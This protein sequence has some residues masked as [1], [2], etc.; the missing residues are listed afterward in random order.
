MGPSQVPQTDD[1]REFDLE[2]AEPERQNRRQEATLRREYDREA[3]RRRA[4]HEAQAREWRELAQRLASERRR[5]TIQRVK[6]RVI[7]NWSALGYLIPAEAKAQALKAVEA[8]LGRLRVEE[9]P[10]AEVM[11]LAEGVRDRIFRPLMRPR[12]RRG[13]NKSAGSAA[14]PTSSRRLSLT[15][16]GR[17]SRRTWTRGRGSASPRKSPERWRTRSPGMSPSGTSGLGWT[18]SSP[19]S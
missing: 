11:T 17:S 12:T 4:E 7:T 19:R 13:R 2:T 5:A 16:T 18:R 15:R 3:A 10:E 14:A 9:L 8:E 6:D 1:P